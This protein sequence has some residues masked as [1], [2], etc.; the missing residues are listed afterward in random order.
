MFATRLQ[1][2]NVDPL[3]RNQLMGHIPFGDA[4]G[5]GPLGMT[6]IYTHASPA[7]IRRQLFDAMRHR[8]ATE[9]LQR[10]LKRHAPTDSAQSD[11]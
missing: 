11:G 4:K 7:T 6:G 9:I 10:W 5:K 1:E 2:T 3:I 8:P